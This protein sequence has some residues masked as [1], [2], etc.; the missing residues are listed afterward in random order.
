MLS[1]EW[2]VPTEHRFT[3]TCN[4]HSPAPQFKIESHTSEPCSLLSVTIPPL[5]LSLKLPEFGTH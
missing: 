4:T 1:A 5:F 3:W 2:S